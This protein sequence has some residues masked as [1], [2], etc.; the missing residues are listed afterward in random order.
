MD[1]KNL[2]QIS[3]PEADGPEILVDAHGS[4]RGPVVVDEQDRTVL[5]TD[6]ETI[7]IEKE[8]HF[9]IAP[10][11]RPRKVY[12]GMWGQA[13]IITIGLAVMAVLSVILL[14]IFVVVPSENELEQKA[15]TRKRLEAEFVSAQSKYG[16]ITSTQSRVSDLI[17]SVD[18]F[19]S[20]Y[21]PMVST[22]QTALYQRLNGLISAYGLINSTGPDYTPLEIADKNGSG[23][24]EERGRAR[25]RSL[26]PG[27]YVTTTV[28]GPYQ[29][30]RRFIRE[31][32]TGNEFVVISAVELEPSNS[33]S[34]DEAPA[35]PEIGQ[36][37]SVA[38]PAAGFPGMN[39]PMQSG[40]Q[41][42]PRGRTQ[43]QT[44][45]LRLEMAAYFRRTNPV[46]PPAA[47]VDS[48]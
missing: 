9:P 45:S 41:R 47:V 17:T 24:S 28:E 15:A 2:D 3:R 5:L 16:D 34:S 37:G 20:R 46:P 21:L 40:Q 22:G 13:E 6:T 27:V 10:A 18:D 4:N 26:F 38:Q 29:N 43:G 11:N 14:Y 35:E 7:V 12:G 19:E 1:E 33:T 42:R 48:Q 44:V 30:L 8:P 23:E 39:Q 31:I 32:E 36:P 25:F